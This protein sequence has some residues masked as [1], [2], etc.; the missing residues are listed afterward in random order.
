MKFDV[1]V[2]CKNVCVCVCVFVFVFVCVCV[3]VCMCAYV[4][5]CPPMSTLFKNLGPCSPSS[6]KQ[7]LKGLE[8][9]CLCT[10]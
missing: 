10:E 5:V 8:S 6:L 7:H 4:C 3:C 9:A 2:T 1:I